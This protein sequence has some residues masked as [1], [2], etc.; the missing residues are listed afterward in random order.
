[1]LPSRIRPPLTADERIQLVGWLDVQR[2]IVPWKCEGL[3]EGD[4]HRAIVPTSAHMTIAGIVSHLRWVEHL[5]FEV[6]FL[7][8]PAVGPRFDG[9]KDAELL[10]DGV[11]LGEL[12][13]AYG[14]Q[15]ARSNE[16]IGA[17]SLEDTGSHPDFEAS[18]ASLRWILIHLVEEVARHLGHIDII[19]ELLDGEKGYY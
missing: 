10:V 15:W 1:M 7:G 19:R 11:P 3:S 13:D 16:I 5:W 12:L 6:I 14:R 18:K 8:G 9:G 4:A 17:H 2:A